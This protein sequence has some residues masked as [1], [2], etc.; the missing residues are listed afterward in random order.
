V[1][2][3]RELR[4]VGA[5]AVLVCAAEE[6]NVQALAAHIRA[7]DLGPALTEI[8]PCARTVLV[9]GD[10]AALDR[11]AACVDA[12]PRAARAEPTG[13]TV[14]VDVV[15]DGDD[16]AEVCERTGLTADEWAERHGAARHEV[17]YFGF[18][19]GLAFV[20]GV[21]T[22]AQ[23]PRRDE[24]RTSVPA[25]SVAV[26]N[27]YTIVYPGGTPGGWQIVGHTTGPPLWDPARTP[28]NLLAVGDAVVFRRVRA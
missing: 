4:P 18:S 28:P 19:P 14:T 11:L 6:E 7:S 5:D 21:P 16:L 8:V 17:E 10:A 20:A 12:A 25:G 15:Y 2:G 9:V 23:V 13:R 24:P 3:G 27:G 22:D 26:A 1:T